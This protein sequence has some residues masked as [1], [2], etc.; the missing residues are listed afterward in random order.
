VWRG[1]R[2]ARHR[3]RAATLPGRED[4]HARRPEIDARAVVAPGGF[5]VGIVGRGHGHDPIV[6]TRARPCRR[7]VAGTPT[8]VAGGH[9][10]ED[11]AA[12]RPSHRLIERPAGSSAEAHV[13]DRRLIVASTKNVVWAIYVRVRGHPVDTLDNAGGR[14]GTAAAEYL[15]AGQRSPRGCTHYVTGVVLGRYGAGDVRAVP[16]SVPVL[17]IAGEVAVTNHVEIGVCMVDAGVDDVGVNVG[18]AVRAVTGLR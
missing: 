5:C 3:G 10:V 4:V 2:G 7:V 14:P 18:D 11:A 15:H 1:H 16:I 8:V 9:G 12:G 6:G 17:P 13:S